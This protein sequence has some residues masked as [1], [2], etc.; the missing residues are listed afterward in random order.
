M[1][2]LVAAI[3]LLLGAQFPPRG[4]KTYNFYEWAAVAP[5]VV[6]AESGTHDGRWYEFTVTR[7]LRGEAVAAGEV[8]EV[9]LKLANRDRDRHLHR[10]AYNPDPP[11]EYLLLLEESDRK[12]KRKEPKEPRFEL[13]R[14]LRGIRELPAEGQAAIVE[15][16]RHFVE[17]QDLRDDRVVWE[18]LGQLLGS[19]NPLVLETVLDQFLKFRRGEATHL[20]QLRAVLDHPSPGLRERSVRMIGQVLRREEPVAVPDRASLR[21]ALIGTAR[22]DTEPAVRVAAIAALDAF[23]DVATE[24]VLEEIADSD[25]D[26]NVRYQA[27]RRLHER[28]RREGSGSGAD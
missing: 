3:A 23:R 7:V 16:V 20:P 14:G 13:V 17:I 5:V 18:R 19:P 6:V 9:D 24:R 26:Q 27:A 4:P 2:R 1:I 22:R 10:F 8:V 21:A 25:P 11:A 12:K 28:E 15:A